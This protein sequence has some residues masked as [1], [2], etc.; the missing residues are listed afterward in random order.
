MLNVVTINLNFLTSEVITFYHPAALTNLGHS[1]ISG[2]NILQI[3]LYRW[4]WSF[5]SHCML[6]VCVCACTCV[7]LH[8]QNIVSLYLPLWLCLGVSWLERLNNFHFSVLFTSNNIPR[9]NN[10]FEFYHVIYEGLVTLAM[11][12]MCQ[13][14]LELDA[15]RIIHSAMTI[16]RI[17]LLFRSNNGIRY[18]SCELKIPHG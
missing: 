13:I 4:A 1:N 18:E 2:H 16:N 11:M 9:K 14:S 10:F 7:G 5:S 3:N 12:R 17:S 6:C 8:T 15:R